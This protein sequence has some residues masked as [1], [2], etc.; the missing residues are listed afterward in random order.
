MARNLN[1]HLEPFRQRRAVF[2]QKPEN[3]WEVLQDGKNRARALAQ[4][5]MEEVRQAVG[6][7]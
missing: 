6:L 4:Q 3:V 5:T 2:A 1:A 7:P